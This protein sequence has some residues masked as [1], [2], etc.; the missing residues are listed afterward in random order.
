MRVLPFQS[1]SSLSDATRTALARAQNQMAQAQEELASGRHADVGRTLGSATSRTVSLRK[2]LQRLEVISDTNGVAGPRLEFTQNILEGLN[3]N[4]NQLL[5]SVLAA[6]GSTDGMRATARAA[7]DALKLFD[8]LMGSSFNGVF[9]FGGENTG[10]RPLQSYFGTPPGTN[11]TALDAAFQA[12]FGFAQNDPAVSGISAAQMNTFLSG[13]FA[14]QFNDANW[15][16]N[17]SQASSVNVES[18]ITP[19]ETIETSVNANEPAFRKLAQAYSML[20]DL[21]LNEMNEGASRAVLDRA[22]TLLNEGINGISEVRATVGISQD[23]IAKANEG[24][25]LQKDILMYDIGLLE[26][27]DPS[28]VSVRINALQTQIEAS[29]AL[30]ARLQRLSIVNFL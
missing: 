6:R 25:S 29:Y 5:S 1:T 14:A 22:M 7:N 4:A 21:G 15:D 28:E 9:V 2:D 10:E 19:T 30:T 3:N 27:V 26:D 20:A 8:Q 12:E 13:N 17:W 24:M 18:R 16:A 11:K 23:R